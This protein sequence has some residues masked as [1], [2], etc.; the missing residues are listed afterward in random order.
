MVK[1][2]E[3]KELIKY[4]WNDFIS[5][6]IVA[7]LFNC[8]SMV[9]LKMFALFC[10]PPARVG[11]KSPCQLSKPHFWKIPQDFIEVYYFLATIADWFKNIACTNSRFIPRST[12][13][14][15]PSGA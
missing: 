15:K 6:I 12:G 8:A 2:V 10:N 11:T 1:L 4:A 13:K 14:I 5:L 7:G 3:H 9:M